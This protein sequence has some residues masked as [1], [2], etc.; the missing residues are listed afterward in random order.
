MNNLRVS[1]HVLPLLINEIDIQIT[2]ALLSRH[3]SAVCCSSSFDLVVSPFHIFLYGIVNKKDV[4]AVIILASPAL[5][6]TTQ[7][8]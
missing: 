7:Q 1:Y 2:I 3:T 4:A 6:L 8:M 5:R